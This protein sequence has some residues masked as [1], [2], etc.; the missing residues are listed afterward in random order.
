MPRNRRFSLIGFVAC[1]TAATAFVVHACPFCPP[2][3]ATLSEKLAQS[4]AACV[5][6]FVSSVDGEELSMQKTTFEVLKQVRPS[7]SYKPSAKI[8]IPIGVTGKPGDLFLL[9]GQ[10]TND[11]MEWSLPIEMDELGREEKYLR[12]APPLESPPVERLAYFLKFLDDKNN[13][14]STDAFSEFAKSKFEDVEQLAPQISRAKVRAWLE[15]PNPQLIVRRAFYGMLLGLCGNDSD[16]EFLKQKIQTM[17]ANNNR[18]GVEGLMGGYLLLRGNSGLQSMIEQK[19]D[20][21]PATLS[22]DDPR[23]SDLNGFRMTLSFLWDYRRSQFGE[24]PLRAAMRRYLKRPEFADLAVVDL[25]RWKDWKPLDQLVAAYGRAPWDSR[26]AKEKIVAYA[27]SCRKDVPAGAGAKLPDHA[28]K[29]QS[30]LDSLDPEF[31][32]SVKQAGGG[33]APPV[34][35]PPKDKQPDTTSN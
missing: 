14:I 5:V 33:L 15:D 35:T 11:E 10:L 16:A 32:Q 8:E 18:I 7:D 12:N 22:N 2:T 1:I 4:E 19:I 17:D 26:S 21:L 13:T 6:K 34:K 28:A 3:D 20:S 9:M 31:V 29:A 27:L 25:S 24:E 30:F 23:L